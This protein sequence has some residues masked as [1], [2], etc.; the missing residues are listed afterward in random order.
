[1]RN[2]M[3]A[4]GRISGG[5]TCRVRRQ[6]IAF[7][8]LRV[9]APRRCSGDGGR[10]LA[11]RGT[12]ALYRRATASTPSSK[13]SE[14]WVTSRPWRSTNATQPKW[15]GCCPVR[16]LSAIVL[17]AGGVRWKQQRSF[18]NRVRLPRQQ[19]ALSAPLVRLSELPLGALR[20]EDEGLADV[21]EQDPPGL[22]GPGPAAA[23]RAGEVEGDCLGLC[24]RAEIIGRRGP[25]AGTS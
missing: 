13:R 22:A 12:P 3:K 21:G 2:Q 25:Y 6:R 8:A 1:M 11:D 14:H 18:L 10:E 24:H 9:R 15:R 20:A 5:A 17:A 23:L 19:T 7:R 16:R 4:S